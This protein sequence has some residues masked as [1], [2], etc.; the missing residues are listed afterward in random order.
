VAGCL[1]A[2]LKRLPNEVGNNFCELYTYFKL[3]KKHN[4]DTCKNDQMRPIQKFHAKI[5]CLKNSK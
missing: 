5:E 3:A 2:A 4:Q 1:S